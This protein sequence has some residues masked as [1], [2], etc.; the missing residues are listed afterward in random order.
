MKENFPICLKRSLLLH[1]QVDTRA[2][3]QHSDKNS[4]KEGDT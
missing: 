4:L 2:A 3:F 1:K